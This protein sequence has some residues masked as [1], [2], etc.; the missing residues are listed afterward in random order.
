MLPPS[1]QPSDPD[2]ATIMSRKFEAL[3]SSLSDGIRSDNRMNKPEL[4][5]V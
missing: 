5:K 2:R 4:D 1:S 3:K